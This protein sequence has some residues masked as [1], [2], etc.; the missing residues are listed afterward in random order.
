MPV[1]HHEHIVLM[2]TSMS[3]DKQITNSA[4]LTFTHTQ[5]KKVSKKLKRSTRNNLEVNELDVCNSPQNSTMM[6]IVV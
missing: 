4:P 1:L 3:P 2:S 6:H 5:E